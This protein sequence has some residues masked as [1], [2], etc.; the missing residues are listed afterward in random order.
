MLGRLER[1]ERREAWKNEATQFT[2]ASPAGEHLTA[3]RHALAM[4]PSP[5]VIDD[6]VRAARGRVLPS[7]PLDDRLA[8]SALVLPPARR[9]KGYPPAEAAVAN[10]K[11]FSRGPNTFSNRRSRSTAHFRWVSRMSA[12]SSIDPG[13]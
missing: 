3:W 1:V 11:C 8:A 5:A 12:A 10:A 2:V 4:R 6:V 13:A 7:E 9:V